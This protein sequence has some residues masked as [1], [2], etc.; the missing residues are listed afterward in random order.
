MREGQ[1]GRKKATLK[2]SFIYLNSWKRPYYCSLMFKCRCPE[3]NVFKILYFI[4]SI[5]LD[6]ESWDLYSPTVFLPP[7]PEGFGSGDRLATG[8]QGI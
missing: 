6:G 1:I 4:M 7:F 2:K 8:R 3:E 5:K